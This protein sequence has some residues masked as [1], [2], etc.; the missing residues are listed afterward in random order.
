MSDTVQVSE[1]LKDYFDALERLKSGKPINVPKSLKISLD[2]VALEAGR[3]K[4]AI[5]KSRAI[6]ADLITEINKVIAEKK[7]ESPEKSKIASLRAEVADLN[8]A[9]EKALGREISLL[10]ENYELKKQLNQL[11]GLAVLPLRPI[12][13][14][15]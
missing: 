8:K 4:G 15:S 3:N 13:S 10:Y 2:A 9:L 14:N 12:K 5:K 7:A 6:Y 11:N 1:T